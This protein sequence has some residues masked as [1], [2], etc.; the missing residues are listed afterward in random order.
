MVFQR[1]P[2]AGAVGAGRSLALTGAKL[3]HIGE[4]V[5]PLNATIFEDRYFNQYNKLP[6][7]PVIAIPANGIRPKC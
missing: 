5:Q 1:L 7:H 4:T 6:K 2:A 3:H